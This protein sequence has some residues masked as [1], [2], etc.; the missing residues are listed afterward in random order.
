MQDSTKAP[1]KAR[2]KLCLEH[3]YVMSATR[4]NNVASKISANLE[5]YL[6]NRKIKSIRAIE[7]R[8]ISVKTNRQKITKIKLSNLN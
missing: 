5:N 2:P 7:V 3:I 1:Q 8:K 6:F 4:T